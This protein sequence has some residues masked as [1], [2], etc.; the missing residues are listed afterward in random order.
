MWIIMLV[1]HVLYDSVF[2]FKKKKTL[3]IYSYD[4]QGKLI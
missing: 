3:K 1:K 4:F 2:R